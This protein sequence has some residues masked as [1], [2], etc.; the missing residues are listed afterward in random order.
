MWMLMPKFLLYSSLCCAHVVCTH[1]LYNCTYWLWLYSC[2]VD[3]SEHRIHPGDTTQTWH[4]HDTDKVK[5]WARVPWLKTQ[6]HCSHAHD[7]HHQ[8]GSASSPTPKYGFFRRNG[9][10]SSYIYCGSQDLFGL[11]WG[12]CLFP[13]W[14]YLVPNLS[15]S[16]LFPFLLSLSLLLL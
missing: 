1:V 7:K 14:D 3:W 4:T 12:W 2:L 6:V 9:R 5:C 10:N 16:S 13:P 11:M 15:S 8:V